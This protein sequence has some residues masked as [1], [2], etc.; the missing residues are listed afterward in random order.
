MKFFAYVRVKAQI[1]ATLHVGF[2]DVSDGLFLPTLHHPRFRGWIWREKAARKY[3]FMRA[4][5]F[6][7]L[8]RDFFLS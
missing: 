7:E 2:G 3:W 1:D 5:R 6:G 4:Q 8:I